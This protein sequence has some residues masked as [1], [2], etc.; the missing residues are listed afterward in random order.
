M[1]TFV[2][3]KRNG[4]NSNPRHH[5]W[6]VLEEGGKQLGGN[7]V[8]LHYLAEKAEFNVAGSNK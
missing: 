4:Q 2:S 1:K 5:A 8:I 7:Q 6:P 3:H